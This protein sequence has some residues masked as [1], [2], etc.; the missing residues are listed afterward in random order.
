[1]IPISSEIMLYGVRSAVLKLIA[2]AE[3]EETWPD[4]D[5][6]EV[7]DVAVVPNKALPPE[8]RRAAPGIFA[9]AR[10][11]E[12]TLKSELETAGYEPYAAVSLGTSEGKKFAIM[13]WH[14]LA[15]D[16]EETVPSFSLFDVEEL[17]WYHDETAEFIVRFRGA[18]EGDDDDDE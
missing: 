6:I 3:T 12:E 1:M 4:F 16:G 5:D 18:M 17:R 10:V 2:K 11:D 9:A 8:A 14:T 7:W 13:H 15:D